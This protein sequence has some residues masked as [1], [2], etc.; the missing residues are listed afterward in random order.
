MD[1]APGDITAPL[2]GGDQGFT[3]IWG[4]IRSLIEYPTIRLEYTILDRAQIQ[5]A[6][7]GPV[8]GDVPQP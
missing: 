2:H 8:L 5:L 3:A 1:D 6:L 4:V 7:P